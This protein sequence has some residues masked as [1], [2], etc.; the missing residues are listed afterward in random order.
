MSQQINLFNPVF[1][2]QKKLFSL[3]TMLQGLGLIMLGSA[4]FHGYAVYQVAMLT[5]QSEETSKRYASEQEKLKR[6]NEGFSPKQVNEAL[7][8]ELKVAEARL[9]AQNEI[10][11]TLRSGV[12]GN[13]TG[14]SEYMR[15]FARQAAHGLWLT[16]FNIVGDGAQMSISGAVLSPEL[17]PAYIRRLGQEKVMSG[18]SVASLQMQRAGDGA[19]Y[20]E[21]TL[22]SAESGGAAKQ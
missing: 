20:V 22:Q 6:Y 1:L 17:V 19:R 3:V 16:H 11:E 2:K 5:K 10:V 13:T 4:L 14:Y 18:K 21:F 15:A 12:I 9:S 8:G 7:E